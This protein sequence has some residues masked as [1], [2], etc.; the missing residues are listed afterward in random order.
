MDVSLWSLVYHFFA[1]FFLA[2][3]LAVSCIKGSYKKKR[4]FLFTVMTS[5]VYAIL[6]ELH[7]YFVPGRYMSLLD[8][9]V[10]SLG[11]LVASAIYFVRVR[12]K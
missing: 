9:G 7:Q 6:D 8:M 12:R 5:V 2:F 4:L 3:F 10:D 11:I 1:F